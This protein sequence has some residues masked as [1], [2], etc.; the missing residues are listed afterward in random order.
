M[1]LCQEHPYLHVA[2]EPRALACAALATLRAPPPR[3]GVLGAR[4]Q[5]LVLPG[6]RYVEQVEHVE[7]LC[8][9]H[10]GIGSGARVTGRKTGLN[11]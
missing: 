7:R 6:P 2:L 3:D 1:T 10:A 5:L 11:T 8:E 4:A 9:L